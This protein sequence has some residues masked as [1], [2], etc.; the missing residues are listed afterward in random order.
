MKAYID[1]NFTIEDD[2]S[3]W[4]DKDKDR[5]IKNKDKLVGIFKKEFFSRYHDYKDD[6]KDLDVTITFEDR[7]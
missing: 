7:S 1:V 4:D 5:V 3:N 2:L 6:I